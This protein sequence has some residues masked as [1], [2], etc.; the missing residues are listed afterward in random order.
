MSLLF[1][2]QTLSFPAFAGNIADEAE[3]NFQL[4]REAYRQGD[5][6][7]ALFHFMVSNRLSPNRAVTFNIGR[8][9]QSQGRFP[10]AYRWYQS[11]LD[12]DEPT[13]E[14]TLEQIKESLEGLKAK[15][16]LLRVTSEPPGA[17]VY[18]DRKA[19][20]SVGETPLEIPLPPKQYM[21]ILEMSGHEDFETE[22]IDLRRQGDI[23]DVAHTMV[24]IVGTVEV[25]GESGA[26]VHVGTEEAESSC[27][28]PCSLDLPEG[29]QILYFKKEGFRSLPSL[30]EVEQ[31]RTVQLAADLLPITGTLVV[32]ADERG[33]LIEIDGKPA[34]YTPAVLTDVQ[35][36]DHVVTVSYR[37]YEPEEIEVDIV[38]DETVDL[39]RVA[40]R[41]RFQVTAASRF[42]ENVAEA[43]A[44]VTLI[45]REEI[46]AF[47]YQSVIEAVAGVRGLYQTSD[48]VYDYLG[49]RGFGRLGDFNNR[50]LLTVDGHRWNENVFGSSYLGN[51]FFT[52]LEDVERVEV[53][54]GPGS[55]LYGSNAFFGVLNVVT[56]DGGSD[57]RPHAVI[58]GVNGGIRARGSVGFGDEEMGAWASVGGIY[59]PGREYVFAEYADNPN[60]GVS[61]NADETYSRSLAAKAW[62]GDF[63]LQ[64][65]YAGREKELPTGQ[66]GT[67]LGDPRAQ[68]G[69]YRGFLE[70][71]YQRVAEKT[72]VDVRA[73]LDTYRNN[74]RGP[75]AREY[76]FNDDHVESWFGA[77]AQLNQ[78]IGT[79][80]ELTAGAETRQDLNHLVRS[81]EFDEVG[82]VPLNEEAGEPPFLERDATQATY[83]GYGVVDIRA[84]DLVRLNLGGRVDAYNWTVADVTIDPLLSPRGALILT[85]GDETVKLMAGQA[86]RAPSAFELFYDDGGLSS[87]APEPGSLRPEQI[88]TID[89]EWTHSFNEILTSTFNAYFNQ[90]DNLIEDG[91]DDGAA[92]KFNTLEPVRTVGAE[93]E[94]RRWWRSGWMF[95]GQV[96]W[97]TTNLG[98]N[99]LASGDD[100]TPFTNSPALLGTLMG[101][102]PL[103]PN[104]TLASKLRGETPRV[105]QDGFNTNGAVLWDVTLTGDIERP[106]VNFGVGVRNLLDWDE[107]HPGGNDV[108][109]DELP[110]RGRSL[111]ATIKI[112]I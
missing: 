94:V 47:G 23:K 37:G 99:F 101:A 110:Q 74:W 95:A 52:D 62:V 108:E 102:A 14:R 65:A 70:G 29:T 11:A 106:D 82:G 93:F 7:R 87:R 36:G 5:F 18:L 97:Q 96:S 56:R 30:I 104:V 67:V 41:P 98:E 68:V 64:G 26:T 85:P 63:T 33:S 73:Y 25:E 35:V 10:E 83:S 54:R 107:V 109:M 76:I 80:I 2:L 72:S 6:D 20:G 46:R 89:A 13:S 57:L 39:G 58:T 53:V 84:G 17:T 78:Q 43:P 34:G 15:V 100:V 59:N 24:P 88:L 69:D 38:E 105:T 111:F 27:E 60:E 55:A 31:G 8:T 9:Y 12:S 45:P 71:R 16:A 79:A 112:N 75:Y 22:G 50:I 92:V 32:D 91:L 49:V 61:A 21:V 44:S 103:L 77:Q 42:A 51:D 86:F 40:L 48:L 90:I 1:L 4:A 81:F 28:V 66:F 19:L 3:V